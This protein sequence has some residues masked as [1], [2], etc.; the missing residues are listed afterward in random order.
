MLMIF[1]YEFKTW[2]SYFIIFTVEMPFVLISKVLLIMPVAKVTIK[3]VE[4]YVMLFWCHS[5]HDL[6][7][8]THLDTCSKSLISHCYELLCSFLQLHI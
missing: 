2:N 1:F 3:T 5:F 6:L 4:C 7:L 8:T